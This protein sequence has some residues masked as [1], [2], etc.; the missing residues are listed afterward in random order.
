MLAREVVLGEV[1]GEVELKETGIF[2]SE[3]GCEKVGTYGGGLSPGTPAAE[4]VAPRRE[5]RA[6]GVFSEG[7]DI[8]FGV[9]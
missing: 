1:N 6:S 8:D 2:S 4:W 3:V 9:R 7:Y 5:A